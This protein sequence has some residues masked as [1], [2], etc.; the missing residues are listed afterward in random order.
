V[1]PR[2]C[3]NAVEG[4]RRERITRGCGD[5]EQQGTKTGKK[6]RLE[7]E[8]LGLLPRVGRVTEVTVRGG[9]EVL[10]LLEVELLNDESGAEVK[11]L[12]DDLHEL[13]VGLLAGAVG[14]DEDGEGLG[15]TDGVRE[16]DEGTAGETGGDEGLGDPSGGV[17]G[18]TVD[19]GPVLAGEGTTTVGTPTAVG[20][21][22]D[23]S[24]G[25]T[26]VTLRTTNDE[27]AG[28]LDVVD[29]ALVEEVLGDDDLDDLL[30]DLLAEVLGGDLL[31]V[32]GRDDDSVHTEGDDGARGVLPVLDGD[33]GLG[34]G[35]EPAERAVATG[36]GHGGVELVGEGDGEG[37]HLRGLVGSVAEPESQRQHGSI[38][39]QSR[40]NL[41]DWDHSH[42]TLVTGTDVLER[43][44]VET[45]GD[46]GRLLLNGDEDIA[47]LVVEALLGRVVADLLDRVT[48]D[49]LVVDDGLGRDLAEDHDHT[50]LGGG[51][52]GDLGEG[53]L[54]V[55]A[56]AWRIHDDND[57]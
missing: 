7:L 12:A 4:D 52:T 35:A 26:G 6:S 11:V 2:G 37:H 39:S 54:G 30:H 28:R 47:G 20:V 33:L 29:G 16:L 41:G 38:R 24:A 42:D 51:L 14:V 19:L 15:D 18:G 8:L 57:G 56:E 13:G 40:F 34:V 45:L 25:Q 3:P 53:V 55:S 50:G 22:N 36:S 44:V 10:G 31:G 21:D 49:L 43:A 1:G 9:L 48:D 27:S 32:L 5:Y 17:S 23:L 46:V